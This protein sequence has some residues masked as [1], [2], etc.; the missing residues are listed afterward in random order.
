M[1]LPLLLVL[2]PLAMTFAQPPALAGTD[3]MARVRQAAEVFARESHGVVG[4]RV[5]TDT[6]VKSLLYHTTT[7]A[8]SFVVASEALPTR[9]VID[10]LRT[11]GLEAGSDKR[12]EEERKNNEAFRA[13]HKYLRLPFDRRFLDAYTYQWDE[14]SRPGEEP[15]IRFASAVKDEAHG[16]GTMRLDGED[17]V[18]SLH[19]TPNV[20]PNLV[21]AGFVAYQ[22]GEVWQ[23][24][25]GNLSMHGEYQGAYGPIKGTVTIEQ[26]YDRYRRYGSVEAAIAADRD[27]PRR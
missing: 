3:V 8:E 21:S 26:H 27:P 13:G 7:H 10:L 5:V 6:E 25:F 9:L 20:L 4:F 12:Q 16:C 2:L 15:A 23:G 24:A 17:H 19:F 1:R 11:D 18:I 14:A 22:R